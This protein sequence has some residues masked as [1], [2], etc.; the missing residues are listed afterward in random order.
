MRYTHT[1]KK[2][3]KCGSQLEVVSAI[4]QTSPE[5]K[6]VCVCV[7]AS[8]EERGGPGNVGGCGD[9]GGIAKWR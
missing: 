1:K 4:K 5:K 9:G 6:I 3:R 8:L 7:C 2:G